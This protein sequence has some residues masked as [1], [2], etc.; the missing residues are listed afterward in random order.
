MRNN[1]LSVGILLDS[2]SISS[3]AYCALEK[4]IRNND[5]NIAGLIVRQGDAPPEP[6]VLKKLFN[7]ALVFFAIFNRFDKLLTNLLPAQIPD[8]RRHRDIRKLATN[9]KIIEVIPKAGKFSDW[10]LP[11]DIREI[12][13]LNL[14]VLF[15]R[16][17]R[18]L[19]G[20]ILTKCSR[21]GVW[22]FHH[23]NNRDLR[24]Q[25]SG[26]WEFVEERDS[27]GAILQ[28]LSEDLD[29]GTVLAKT[30]CGAKYAYTWGLLL[31]RLYWKASEMLPKC[32]HVVA[33]QGDHGLER[34]ISDNQKPFDVYD[35]VLY[36]H[37]NILS[38]I[39]AI[40]RLLRRLRGSLFKRTIIRSLRSL[41]LPHKPKWEILY[42]FS[43]DTDAPSISLNMRKFKKLF[44]PKGH[45]WS[46]P[47]LLERN[48][49]QYLFFEDYGYKDAKASILVAELTKNGL[50]DSPKTA[51]EEN[52]HISYPHIFEYNDALYM[53]PETRGA[54]Q[55]RL[56]KCVGFPDKW[57]FDSILLDNVS[58]ADSTVFNHDGNWW[59]FSSI[60]SYKGADDALHVFHSDSPLEGWRPHPY[61][62]VNMDV[63]SARPAGNVFMKDGKLFRFAQIGIEY[64]WGV[65]ICEIITLTREYYEEKVVEVIEPRWDTEVLGVHTLNMTNGCVVSDCKL[66]LEWEI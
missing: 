59:L 38:S 23:G 52:F 15:R 61:N 28:V 54:K 32:L 66:T 31:D 51:L 58:A 5:I 10:I 57:E 17:F 65:A 6:C 46:D 12:Q 24:G 33:E 2:Y 1:T 4:S 64:G 41:G 30:M 7:P 55:I 43:V 35:R 50:A 11:A 62:P 39:R 34:L 45:F 14:D 18:I 27:V 56:Y 29:G 26:F 8:P 3:W 49:K 47:F 25:P 60:C 9:A 21:Y 40:F 13:T 53:I 19:R 22:S 37:P 44:A 20:D 42:S 36:L 48:G 63:H 16:G